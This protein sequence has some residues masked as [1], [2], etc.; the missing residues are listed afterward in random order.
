MGT[1]KEAVGATIETGYS[2][3]GGSQEPSS[4]TTAG[5]E[6][7]AKGEAEIRAAEAKAYASG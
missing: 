1:A 5:K 6:Q 4:W 2:A 3:V 7:H